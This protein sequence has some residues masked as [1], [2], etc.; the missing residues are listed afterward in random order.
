MKQIEVLKK[1]RGKIAQGWTRRVLARNI[2]NKSVPPRSSKAIEW[3]ILGAIEAVTNS[4]DEQWKASQALLH[5]PGGPLSMINCFT[6][7]EWNDKAGRT[8]KEVLAAFDKTI[9]YLENKR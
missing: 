4:S 2:N 8:Q 5:T 1:A 9:K 3:C 7:A 6:V